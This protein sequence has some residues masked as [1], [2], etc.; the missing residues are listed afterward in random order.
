[1]NLA[2]DIGNTCIKT[3]VFDGKEL[4]RV[5]TYN[6]MEDL[7]KDEALFK[8][9]KCISVSSVTDAHIDLLNDKKSL[10]I[11]IFSKDTTIPLINKY[12]SPETLGA[13]RILASL[14]SFSLF[15]D[16]NVLTIDAG[17]CIKYNFVNAKNEF[18]GGAISPGLSMRLKAMNQFTFKLPLADLDMNY[19]KL[20]GTNTQ[21][22]LLSGGLIGA[23]CEVESFILRYKEAHKQLEVCVTGGDAPYLCKQLKNRFFADAHLVLKGLNSII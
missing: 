18:L 7:L 13:D 5:Q 16:R 21:E 17:T 2:I 12:H 1:M 8:G 22:S 20:T 6:S 3:G 4:L 19:D 10:P 15:P 14:G 23:V 11:R 9:I